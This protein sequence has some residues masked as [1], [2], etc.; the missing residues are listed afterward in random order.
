MKLYYA[1]KTRSMRAFWILE[2]AGRPYETELVDF[3]GGRHSTPEYHRINPMEKVPALTDG[4]A[5]VAE[6]AAICAY[7]AERCPEAGLAPPVGD[8]KRG[9]Y[10]QW[11]FFHAN[12]EAAFVQKFA[13]VQIPSSQAGWGDFDRVFDVIDETLA[14]GGPWMLGERFSAAD[15]MIGGDLYLGSEGFKLV[16]LKPASAAYLARCKERPAFKRAQVLNQTGA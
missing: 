12:V 13:N 1:P 3:R 4:E 11:L 10:L 8:A 16:T 9:R 5:A 15:V 14:A 7:V 2:E 6:S